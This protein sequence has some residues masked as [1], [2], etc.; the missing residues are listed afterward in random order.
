MK[1]LKQFDIILVNMGDT[2][3]REQKGL[4]PCLVLE[5][6]GFQHKGGVIIVAPLTINLKRITSIE[7]LIEPSKENGLQESSVLL[8][9]QLRA[10][11]LSRIIKKIGS[12]EPNY[13][14][15]I[16]VSLGILFDFMGDFI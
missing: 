12:L 14:N 11:D 10:I 8:F 9:R 15:D 4:R 2:L 6:N 1:Q 3:G 7:T 5:S 16:H 13:H